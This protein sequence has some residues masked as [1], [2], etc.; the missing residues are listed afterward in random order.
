MSPRCSRQRFTSS[1]GTFS[2]GSGQSGRQWRSFGKASAPMRSIMRG[3]LRSPQRTSLSRPKRTSPAKPVRNGMPASNGASAAFH[4]R[5]IT[6]AWP[7]MSFAQ[8]AGELA[9]QCEAEAPPRQVDDDRLAHA[10]H[11]VGQGRAQRAA[12]DIH[13]P[14]GRLR[15]QQLHDR[16]AADEIADPDIGDDQDRLQVGGG[17]RIWVIIGGRP[18]IRH[19][20]RPCGQALAC[21]AKPVQPQFL[22][23]P[24]PIARQ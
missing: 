11:V 14:V 1:G 6:S 4:L 17:G 7:V 22:P 24:E 23:F 16:M 19:P 2:S 3:S 13:R 10:R 21:G 15:A 12:D 5:D 8:P 18:S 9:L 20:F